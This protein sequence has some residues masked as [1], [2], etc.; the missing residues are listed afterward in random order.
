MKPKLLKSTG[1]PG[2]GFLLLLLTASFAA[3]GQV[4]PEITIG[5]PTDWTHH[6]L[7]FSDSGPARD[8]H[9]ASQ[10][11]SARS[12]SLLHSTRNALWQMRRNPSLRPTGTRGAGPHQEPTAAIHKDWSKAVSVG[13]VNPNTFP[14]KF[15]FNTT[16]FSCTSDYVVYPTGS[17][18]VGGVIGTILA[19][20]EL[21]GTP[22]PSGTGCGSGAG[23]AAVPTVYW[24]YNTSFPQGS[25]TGDGSS[26]KTSPVL[27]LLGDQVAFIQV[28]SN[29]VASLVILKWSSNSS[30]VALNTATNN[31][32]PANYHACVAPCMTS[33][34]LRGGSDDTW[35]APFYDYDND[36]IYVGD[37]TGELHK[38]AGVF[39]STPTEVTSGYPVVVGTA[40]LASPVYDPTSGLVFFGDAKRH[41]VFCRRKFGSN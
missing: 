7:V 10:I 23:G 12:E 31:V 37:D 6:R 15:S 26:V 5:R 25:T 36:V 4:A 16:T 13:L 41:S 17:P 2:G 39:L 24:A 1:L 22:G 35:S 27:S 14:A 32:P 33:I 19:Y 20:N 29:N 11:H 3:A 40:G 21:Y 28:S 30:V 9:S 8:P 38:I 18:G 34:L